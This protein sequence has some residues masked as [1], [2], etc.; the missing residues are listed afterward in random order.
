[1]PC[2]PVPRW[3]SV[4]AACW[5][6]NAESDA[7]PSIKLDGGSGI[8]PA[9]DPMPRLCPL[10]APVGERSSEAPSI[11]LG[12]KDQRDRCCR[13]GI[14]AFDVKTLLERSLLEW[15]VEELN[16]RQNKDM[17]LT[18]SRRLYSMATTDPRIVI[19]GGGA[20][21]LSTALHLA[22]SGRKNITILDRADSIPSRHS[23]AYDIN[24]IVRAEYEDPFYTKLA[25]VSMCGHRFDRR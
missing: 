10:S 12:Q 25:L 17:L 4:V 16:S 15:R 11:A 23:A 18:A 19:V 8:G 21:G 3:S 20:W 1:M 24:K 14:S 9:S 2:R 22:Q 6:C 7:N 13:A 5:R